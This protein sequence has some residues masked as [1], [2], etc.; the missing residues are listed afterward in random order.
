LGGNCLSGTIFSDY[1]QGLSFAN[2]EAYIVHR[3]DD[4]CI[5]EKI[6]PEVS[7]A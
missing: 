6:G 3:F 7:N 2:F 1:A 5:G 4:A